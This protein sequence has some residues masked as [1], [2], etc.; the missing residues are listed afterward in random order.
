LPR[1]AADHVVTE[2][3]IAVLRGRSV[4]ERARALIAVAAPQHRET[5]EAQWQDCLKAA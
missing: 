5:L 4:Q 2:H 1:Q 3:G